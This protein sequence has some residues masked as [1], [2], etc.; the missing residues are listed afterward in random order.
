MNSK[1]DILFDV[2]ISLLQQELKKLDPQV[3]M[4]FEVLSQEFTENGKS[5][6]FMAGIERLAIALGHI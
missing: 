3:Q 2:D 1:P 6:D 4:Y 5:A